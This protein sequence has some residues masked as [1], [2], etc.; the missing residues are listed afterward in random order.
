MSPTGQRPTRRWKK[1][2]CCREFATRP[3]CWSGLPPTGGA[4]RR[5]CRTRRARSSP[6]P[7][8]AA[9]ARPHGRAVAR[10]APRC[11][12]PLNCG[13]VS[14]GPLA[15]VRWRAH[16][17]QAIEVP[18]FGLAR[19]IENESAYS[20]ALVGCRHTPQR[21]ARHHH[22]ARVLPLTLAQRR[23]SHCELGG[24]AQRQMRRDTGRRRPR[25]LQRLT[26]PATRRTLA[27]PTRPTAQP[28]NM[29]PERAIC[30]RRPRRDLW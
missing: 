29:T 15:R 24:A 22:R 18:V 27:A 30:A 25:S 23:A 10:Q 1:P 13:D 9:T 2:R 14:A 12:G 26:R 6:R 17:S 11:W 5:A 28:C 7:R 21:G 19:D 3:I 8:T 4:S 20:D 16:D